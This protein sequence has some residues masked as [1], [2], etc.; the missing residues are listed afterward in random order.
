MITPARNGNVPES[1]PAVDQPMPLS[2]LDMA[3]ARPKL[4]V[5]AAVET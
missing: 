1:T 4:P 3:T 5:S 2:M